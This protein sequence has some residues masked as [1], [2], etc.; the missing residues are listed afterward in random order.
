MSF[1]F[2]PSVTFKCFDFSNALPIYLI[3]FMFLLFLCGINM[4]KE[5][6]LHCED[7]SV[8]CENGY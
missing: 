4:S 6:K 1:V 3:I 7:V 8:H 2:L 5:F